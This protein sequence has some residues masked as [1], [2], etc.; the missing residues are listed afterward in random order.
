MTKAED[1]A[2]AELQ[3]VILKAI[4]TVE[5]IISLAVRYNP[6]IFYLL[7]LVGED[8]KMPEVNIGNKIEDSCRPLANVFAIV[9]KSASAQT[10][11]Q[12]GE[13]FWL[14]AINNGAVIYNK[15]DLELLPIDKL[16]LNDANRAKFHWDRWG[17]QGK[18]FYKGAEFYNSIDNHR[19]AAFMLHQAV[20][21]TLKAIIQAIV[22]YRVQSHNLSR[23]LNL[24]RLFTDDLVDLFLLQ[25]DGGKANFI[26][27]QN[28][29]SHS[30]Y[31]NDYD[32]DGEIVQVLSHKV[33]AF[34]KRVEM[35]YTQYIT[36]I[37][38]QPE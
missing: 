21:S 29:Y 10:G 36:K 31:K 37:E 17:T 23:L 26:V 20:E 4:P 18:E 6:E 27:L 33:S 14:N 2:L 11:L 9:H 15:S 24:S 12:I 7:I 5:M 34:I 8:E 1:L 25:A 19:L 30:R 22:G 38:I 3:A 13:R 32:P 16:K 28:A 35:I